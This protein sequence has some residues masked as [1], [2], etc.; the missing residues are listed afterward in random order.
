[1]M[2]WTRSKLSVE[3]I[4]LYREPVPRKLNWLNKYPA[5]ER[6]VQPKKN[7]TEWRPVYLAATVRLSLLRNGRLR[8]KRFRR[9]LKHFSLVERAKLGANAKMRGSGGGEGRKGNTFPPPPFHQCCARPNFRTAKK[10]KMPQTDGK[11]Y[12]N[13]CYAGYRNGGA[14]PGK[15]RE[16]ALWRNQWLTKRLKMQC[17]ISK[18]MNLWSALLCFYVTVWFM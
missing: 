9:A 4:G 16:E 8:S 17:H 15:E 12:G 3:M 18:S 6:C 2:V 1:M 7:W 10:Q 11:T 5:L 14:G 13:A